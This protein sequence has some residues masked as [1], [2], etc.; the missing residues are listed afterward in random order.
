M[1]DRHGTGLG[2]TMKQ[3]RTCRLATLGCKVNQYETQHAKELLEANGYRE[4]RAGERA[5]LCLV[6]TC[7]VTREADAQGR[8][9]I[10]RIAR[11]NPGTALVVTGCYATREPETVARLLGVVK[12]VTDKNRLAEELRE[13]GVERQPTG[14]SRFDSHQRAFV[15]VQDGCLLACSFC[16]IPRVRPVLRSRPVEEICDEVRRLVASGYREIVLTGIHLGHYGIDLSRGKPRAQWRR[17]WHLLDQLGELPGEFRIRLSSLEAAEARDDLVRAMAANPRFCPHLHLCL[18]SGSDRILALMKRRY[19][20]GGFIERCR[21]LR[22]ALDQPAFTTDVIV[23]FPGETEADFEATCMVV[24]EVGFVKIHAFPYSR[25][26]GT[27]A[28]EFTG[29]VPAAVVNERRQRLVELEREHASAY[30]QGLRGRGLGVLVEGAD[31]QR[32]GFVRGTSCRHVPVSFEGWA[33]AL[34]RRLV[35]VRVTAV[36]D[37]VLLGR[38]EM[39]TEDRR[40]PLPM[41][42][43]T[44]SWQS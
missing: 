30:M 1:K 3:Q 6:N 43:T 34:V 5:D 44:L 23:G 42:A 11:E 39:E 33:P 36:A 41:A 38:P 27:P 4:A 18:Q 15:K 12:V 25:R 35:P 22:E 28:A 10:R 21:R 40:F 20:S 17:L 13:F 29:A 7:T 14:I 19:R 26:P 37:G 16:I 24:R 31:R 8:Q 2:T 32:P 9:L